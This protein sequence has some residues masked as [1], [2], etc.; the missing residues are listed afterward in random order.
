[1]TKKSILSRVAILALLMAVAG[2]SD[3][4]AR[5]EALE[6]KQRVA[7]LETKIAD[8]ETKLAELNAR[9][10][11]SS[12]NTATVDDRL[13]EIETAANKGLAELQEQQQSDNRKL[14]DL[15]AEMKETV[16]K[17]AAEDDEM[18]KKLKE[19]ML[20]QENLKTEMESY[21][22]GSLEPMVTEIIDHKLQDVYPY[23]FF[24]KRY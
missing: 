17:R 19:G 7:T 20:Y 16:E 6:A 22:E 3:E 11:E 10:G 14:M 8:L 4:Q 23:A 5:K 21:L 15:V 13:R 2:C 24:R 1:M 18:N 12:Q 9:V